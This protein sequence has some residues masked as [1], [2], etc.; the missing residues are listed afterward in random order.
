MV[1]AKS[2][3]RGEEERRIASSD[4]RITNRS[5][6][7]L[8]ATKLVSDTA[9]CLAWVGRG[10]G[11]QAAVRGAVYLSEAEVRAAAGLAK[12]VDFLRADL[13]KAQSKLQETPR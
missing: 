7:P 5:N 4:A 8:F 6:E 3:T 13:A 9:G 2:R 10:A 1:R 11:R 12:P